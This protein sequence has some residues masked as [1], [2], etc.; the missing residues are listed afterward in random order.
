M[1]LISAL[2]DVAFFRLSNESH[3]YAVAGEAV[4]PTRLTSHAW[5]AFSAY[6]AVANLYQKL[7]RP[8]CR[9]VVRCR[10]LH[11]RAGLMWNASLGT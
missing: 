11:C 10:T 2:C 7:V 1:L 5:A 6:R 9:L 8:I 4:L 3:A